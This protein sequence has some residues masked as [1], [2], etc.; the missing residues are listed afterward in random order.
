MQLNDFLTERPLT[1]KEKG[2]KEKYVKGM[3]GAKS[4]FVDRYGKDAKAVMYATATKMAKESLEEKKM[5]TFQTSVGMMPGYDDHTPLNFSD[6]EAWELKTDKSNPKKNIISQR[7]QLYLNDFQQHI[8]ESAKDSLKALA[9]HVKEGVP[10]PDSLF[11]YQSEA[12]FD[13]FIKAKQLREMGSLPELDWESEEM[14]TTDIGESFEL[15]NGETVWLDVPYLDEGEGPDLSDN[16]I[17]TPDSY[18]DEEE[19]KEAYNDLKDAMDMFAKGHEQES[20]MQGICPNCAGTGYQDAEYPEYDDDG[21]EIEGSAFECDGYGMF[22]CDE[23][24]MVGASWVDII[25]H[26]ER[27]AEREKAKADYPGDEAVIDQIARAVKQLDDPRQMYQYMKADYPFMGVAQRSS[28]IAKGMKKAGL[29]TENLDYLTKSMYK[30][31]KLQDIQRYLASIIGEPNFYNIDIVD[32]EKR[33]KKMDP[34]LYQKYADEK[35]GILGEDSELDSNEAAVAKMLAKA[36]G[37]E[38]RWTEMSPHELYAELESE[39]PEMADVIKLTAKMIYDVKLH[40]TSAVKEGEEK[41]IISDKVVDKIAFEF[42]D[43]IDTFDSKE[44]LEYSIYN[45]ISSLDIDDVVDSDMEVGGQRMG[46]F[47]TGRVIDV[48]DSSSVIDDIMSKLDLSQL[49]EAEYNGKK[50]QLNKP[51]RGGSKKYY[52]YVKNP[53]TGRVK[54]ISF[55]DVTGLRTKSGNK[56]RAKSF[57]ARHNCEKKNDKMKA[58]YWA[59][60]L[61]RYGLVKGGKWW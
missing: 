27:K 5:V 60:R 45:E 4:D 7:Y 14:L 25:K 29:T 20:V 56:K 31:S 15:E 51:K 40:E 43:I 6:Y 10:L 59:C 36:L 54:K 17:G 30:D 55:G 2:K 37:D 11:R 24:E 22:G 13:T 21:E 3:K 50:V 26:D 41:S 9:R 23:G 28:L 58:G 1:K 32:L 8:N 34:A 39:N 52:V 42:E 35:K 19:R 49:K 16:M 44:E 47:A 46:D 12:Y 33:L 57:A 18:Y 48:I 53:K 61:P 38:N